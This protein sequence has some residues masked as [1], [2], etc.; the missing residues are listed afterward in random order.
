MSS[1][2]KRIRKYRLL[3][4][5]TYREL[6]E[7]CNLS[8]SFLSEVEH[9]RSSISIDSLKLVSKALKVPILTLIEGEEATKRID[10]KEIL[11]GEM[12]VVFDGNPI[13]MTIREGLLSFLESINEFMTKNKE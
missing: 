6:S 3:R 7:K 5:M 1:I 8:I 10:L 13:D 11:Q 4:G 12:D 2:G 9:G